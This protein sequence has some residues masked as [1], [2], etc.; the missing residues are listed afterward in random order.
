MRRCSL[1]VPA[2]FVGLLFV[3]GCSAPTAESVH[4]VAVS[5]SFG[6]SLGT[7]T[8]YDTALVPVGA[9]ETVTATSENGTTTV[10]LDV[11]GLQPDRTYAAHAHTKPCGTNGD[12]AGPHFQNTA[13]P[14]QPSVDP[15]YANPR[16]EI[17]LDFTTDGSGVGKAQSTVD[18]VFTD[19]RRAHSVVIH[20]K[21]TATDAGHAGMAGA[22][23]AC[24]T[25]GF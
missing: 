8:T 25:V 22:R 13:D 9:Q 15:A 7:A 19:E 18:W 5:S 21:P 4:N 17:W 6:S 2:A 10:R 24:I 12:A 16:N 1:L 11:R 23:A 14:V 3:S 20:A